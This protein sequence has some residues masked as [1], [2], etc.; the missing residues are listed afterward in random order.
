MHACMKDITDTDFHCR[1]Q[2]KMSFLLSSLL[3]DH[4]I[5]K[6]KITYFLLSILGRKQILSIETYLKISFKLCNIA[7]F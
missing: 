6:N 5:L 4:F 1:A 2:N 7:T 3:L